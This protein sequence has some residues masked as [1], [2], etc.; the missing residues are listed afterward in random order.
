M[1]ETAVRETRE[2]VGIGADRIGLVGS[3]PPLWTITGYWVTPVVGF[4]KSTVESVQLRLNTDEIAR[5]FWVPIPIL[6]K[7]GVYRVEFKQV[8]TVQFPIHVYQVGE[9]RIW[10][11]TGAMIKN[12]LDRIE[13]LR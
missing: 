8:G 4:L 11:A 13:A 10:G 1:L 12:F 9:D 7:P 2:E 3:L 6:Q 5:A